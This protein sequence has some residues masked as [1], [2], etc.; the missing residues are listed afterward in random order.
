MAF[1]YLAQS[2]TTIGLLSK[3]SEQL[4]ALKKRPKNKSVLIESADFRTLKSLVRAPN[5]F[6]NLIRRSAKTTFIYP[7]LNA[8]RVIRGRHGD[9][10]KRFKTLYSTS[11]NLTQCTYDKEIASNLA[12]VIVSDERGLFESSSSKIF[13]LYKNKKVRIR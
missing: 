9:F 1:V 13:K 6:K 10:L 2:D 3:D 5:A 8:V 11:A 4:N 12:D 7:N